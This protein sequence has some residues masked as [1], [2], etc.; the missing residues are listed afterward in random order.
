[1]NLT[2]DT[3]SLQRT[4]DQLADMPKQMRYAGALAVTKTA[5]RVQEAEI[6]EMRDSFDRPTAYT[7]GATF[8]RPATVQRPEAI[9]GIKDNGFGQGRPAIQWLRWQ[10][11]GGLR[12]LTGYENL[13]VGAGLMRGTDR[14]VPGRFARLDAYGNISR[15]QVVQILSQ[16]RI[17]TTVGSTRS[18]PRFAFDDRG[19]DRRAKKATIKRAYKRAGGQFIALP[20]GRGRLQPGIYQ[21]RSTAFGRT[22]PKPVLI[23]VPKAS[24]EPGRFDFHYTAQQAINKHF[25]VELRAAVASTLLTA[26]AP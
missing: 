2:I 24:Y 25:P 22:D 14:A 13:L 20:D 23:F 7:L 5:K 10:I 26:K 9:V 21:V 12:S 8:V 3:K 16:L 15:G 4:L 11:Y 19:R 18:L 1:M 6:A 17:D